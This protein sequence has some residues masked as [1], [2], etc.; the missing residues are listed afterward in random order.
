NSVSGTQNC[1]V[2]Q[3]KQIVNWGKTHTAGLSMFFI[4]GGWMAISPANTRWFREPHD[5]QAVDSL[6]IE[7]RKGA[8]MV[9]TLPARFDAY[10]RIGSFLRAPRK[11][12][13]DCA[14]LID[15][16]QCCQV[17]PWVIRLSH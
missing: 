5:G 8:R 15:V 10:G 1:A 9:T 12:C 3:C 6:F 4:P 11:H 17:S 2:P 16:C 14:P 13:G 7:H